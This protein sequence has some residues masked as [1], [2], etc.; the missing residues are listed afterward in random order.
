MAKSFEQTLLERLGADFEARRSKVNLQCLITRNL[1]DDLQVGVLINS[2]GSG[3]SVKREVRAGLRV[4]SVEQLMSE[5][6]VAMQKRMGFKTIAALCDLTIWNRLSPVKSAGPM[7]LPEQVAREIDCICDRVLPDVEAF[8]EALLE[9]LF[10][11]TIPS[12]ASEPVG[13]PLVQKALIVRALA[14]DCSRELASS[15]TEK[16]PYAAAYKQATDRFV[17]WLLAN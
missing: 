3:K 13:A 1:S 10:N 2:S 5:Y 11:A 14:G 4:P 6:S 8:N 7:I 17:D 16:T 15:L 9:L 12:W